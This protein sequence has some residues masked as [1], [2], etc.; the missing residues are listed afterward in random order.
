MYLSMCL[1]ELISL[2][3]NIF[4]SLFTFKPLKNNKILN[5][6]YKDI[7]RFSTIIIIGRGYFSESVNE[8]HL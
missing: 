8:I 6:A 5:F 7:N 2:G 1:Q 4:P 3:R